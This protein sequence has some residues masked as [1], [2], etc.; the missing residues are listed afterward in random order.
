[1]TNKLE[2]TLSLVLF[3]GYF[4]FRLPALEGPPGTFIDTAA[5]TYVANQPFWSW[6][7]LCGPR[8]FILP[9]VYKLMGND[10]RGIIQFQ[11][12]LAGI[13]WLA[14]A[15]MVTRVVNTRWLKAIALVTILLFSLSTNIVIW[16]RDLLTESISISLLVLFI[17]CWFW[18]LMRWHWAKAALLVLIAF[19]LAFLRDA[20]AYSLMLLAGLLAVLVLLKYANWRYLVLAA[21]FAVIF[22]ANQFSA[23]RGT[24]WLFPFFDVMGQRILVDPQ[25]IE[26]FS[27]QGM[28][29]SPALMQRA[30][31]W[32]Y[33]DDE[34]FFKSAEL[35]VFRDW[36]K[37]RGK[38]TYAKFLFV[39]PGYLLL[40]PL[41][42]WNDILSGDLP[43]AAAPFRP[44]LPAWLNSVV[45]PYGTIALLVVG[46]AF[47]GFIAA[48]RRLQKELMIPFAMVLIAIP[49]TILVWHAD[50]Q[51]TARH[52]VTAAIQ[53]RLAFWLLFLFVVDEI[54]SK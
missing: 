19:A 9:L 10:V 51:E 45:Y 48:R 7:F 2:V 21:A 38:V 32:A 39:H 34:A 44:P 23:N 33:S 50:A 17:S 22:A 25:R 41:R 28:P 16:E 24:R 35:S 8:P 11:W 13:C 27:A 5:Y 53:I 3:F 15:M 6:E 20:N 36:A 49:S 1:M 47:T 14:L 46:C 30:G 54:G 4:F 29:V 40:A 37:A 42:E 18:L 26:Y 12:G 43:Y 31:K 52:G